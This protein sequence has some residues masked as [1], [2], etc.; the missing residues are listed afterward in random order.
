MYIWTGL[1]L[2]SADDLITPVYVAPTRRPS[3]RKPNIPDNE[4]KLCDDEDCEEGSGSYPI[5]VPG[6]APK[7]STEEE[8]ISRY[9]L[10]TISNTAEMETEM[11]SNATVGGTT[12]SSFTSRSNM[13]SSVPIGT[14]FGNFVIDVNITL[15]LVS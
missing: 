15:K 6:G 10:S 9:S 5:N 7:L 13:T 11:V 14:Y 4:I 1:Y 2:N 3:S 8:I 12:I